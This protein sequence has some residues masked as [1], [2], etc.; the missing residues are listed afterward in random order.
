MLAD[1][2]ECT[3]YEQLICVVSLGGVNCVQSV[4]QRLVDYAADVLVQEPP[5][6]YPTHFHLTCADIVKDAFGV[7]NEDRLHNVY[8]SLHC[9]VQT[10]GQ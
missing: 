3:P 4:S 5:P 2:T 6:M 10:P 1:A 9:N 8:L 7:T